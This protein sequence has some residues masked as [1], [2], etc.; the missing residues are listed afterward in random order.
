MSNT[1]VVPRAS[2]TTPPKDPTVG[3]CLGSYGGPGEVDD[4]LCA[5]YP[6][7]RMLDIT[8]TDRAVKS[9]TLPTRLKFHEFSHE[10]ADDTGVCPGARLL[11]DVRV[12]HHRGTSLTK[13]STLLGPYR[14][15][16][17]RV[18]GGS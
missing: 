13:K 9:I 11:S 3:L 18:L 10:I 5:R 16:M 17:P 14:R 1:S 15:P 7:T 12:L 4:F 6:C 8:G 2:E